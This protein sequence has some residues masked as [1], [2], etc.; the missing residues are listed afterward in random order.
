MT[1]A[2]KSTHGKSFGK[3][4]KFKTIPLKK[5]S[6][7]LRYGGVMSLKEKGKRR[8]PLNSYNQLELWQPC[9]IRVHGDLRGKKH[10]V[11]HIHGTCILGVAHTPIIVSKF[12]V[13]SIFLTVFCF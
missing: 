5:S 13:T 8:T 1:S 4:L 9:N 2:K 6:W 12:V 7:E 3:N 11:C 10:C